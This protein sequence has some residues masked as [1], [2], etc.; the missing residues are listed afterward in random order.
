MSTYENQTGRLAPQSLL[1]QRYC[2]VGQAGRGGMGTVYQATDLRIA[3]RHVAIKEMSQS[4]LHPTELAAATARFQQEAAM[5]GALSHPN[6]PRIYDAFNEQN[7]FYLVMDYIEGKTLFELIKTAQGRP[8]PVAQVLSYAMQLCDV[9]DYLH[10]RQPA[11]IFRDIKPSNIMVKPGGQIFLIDF[12]IARFFKEGQQQDTV[13]LGSPGYAAPEQH[14]LSQT[15]QRTD[16]YGLGATLHYCLTGRD[17][18]HA[19]DPFNFPAIRQTNPQVPLELDQLIQR[20]VAHDE[21]VRPGSA[22]EV[23]QALVAISQQATDHT[24][25]L[26]PAQAATQ[27]MLSGRPP[28]ALESA[29]A[30]TVAVSTSQNT[31]ATPSSPATMPAATTPGFAFPRTPLPTAQTSSVPQTGPSPWSPGFLALFGVILVVALGASVYA[32]SFFTAV[33]QPVYFGWALLVETGLS[34]VLLLVAGSAGSGLQGALSRSILTLTGIAGLVSGIAALTLGWLDLQLL[35]NPI[36]PPQ[37]HYLSIADLLLVIAP[38]LAAL[39][40]LYWPFR[41]T[42]Q[43]ERIVLF[44]LFGVA[45]L[46]ALLQGLFTISEA[47]RHLLLLGSLIIL[48]QSVLYATR[49]ERIRNTAPVVV[50]GHP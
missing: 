49:A 3:Q 7:R 18:Y 50:P 45:L 11:I 4:K 41:A 14:G 38:A 9:L 21:Q 42:S 26:A 34:L 12:G 40:S 36:L 20:M 32:T 28:T 31:A 2:I 29:Q 44:I 10:S 35:L 19:K 25:E 24:S 17:P 13:L 46:C 43:R 47:P 16:I 33:G 22:R 30:P 6:L 27:Y 39:A 23:Q 5:L 37:M 1:Q 48:V 8:L 15:N